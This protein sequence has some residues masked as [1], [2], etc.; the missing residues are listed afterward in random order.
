MKKVIILTV[1]TCITF[2]VNAQD[3]DSLKKAFYQSYSLDSSKQYEQ[4]AAVLKTVY[5]DSDYEINLRLGW[6]YYEAGK[7]TDA[8]AYYQKAIA[9]QPNSIEAKL[10]I[11]Y[12]L[13]V[14][15]NWDEVLN[16]YLNIL[17]IDS[18][19][20]LVNYRV[21]LM[22][23]NSKNYT[24]AKKYLDTYLQIYPFDYDALVLSGWNSIAMNN[25][26]DAKIYFQKALLNH[27]NDTS[28]KQGLDLTN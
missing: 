7:N 1:F 21:S 2:L 14:I 18:R 11:V 27:P 28:A 16:Q 3:F 4:A 26:A 5:S 25:K 6:L 15:P 9:I 20:P 23:Y 24:E 10:G 8:I 13:S 17:K 12:P 22:Y 19:Q